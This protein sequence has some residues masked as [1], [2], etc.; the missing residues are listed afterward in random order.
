[1]ASVRLDLPQPFGPTMPVRPGSIR[2][3]VLSQKLLKPTMRRRLNFMTR[4]LRATAPQR[5]VAERT[6]DGD[7][8]GLESRRPPGSKIDAREGYKASQ[9]AFLFKLDRV[10]SCAKPHLS[11]L[12]QSRPQLL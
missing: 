7:R 8:A 6:V 10:I 3:S 1:M 11:S 9:A 2:K 5:R 12:N 4:E